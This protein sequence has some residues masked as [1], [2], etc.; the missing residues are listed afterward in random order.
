MIEEKA[1]SLG[2]SP[3]RHMSQRRAEITLVDPSTCRYRCN[4]CGQIWQPMIQSG[5][6][7]P[8]GWWRCPEGCNADADRSADAGRDHA[9]S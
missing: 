1:A 9:S 3:R 7:R 6:R 5:G 2:G 4:C 8:R